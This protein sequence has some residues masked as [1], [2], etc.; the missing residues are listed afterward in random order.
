MSRM[1]AATF[2]YAVHQFGVF[3]QPQSMSYPVLV[4]TMLDIF[5]KKKKNGILF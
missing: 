2:L 4:S 1:M 3:A 5:S